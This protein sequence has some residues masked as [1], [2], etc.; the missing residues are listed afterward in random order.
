M[1]GVGWTRRGGSGPGILKL[2]YPKKDSVDVVQSDG[3]CG[4]IEERGGS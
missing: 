4:N 3:I 1:F 2:N